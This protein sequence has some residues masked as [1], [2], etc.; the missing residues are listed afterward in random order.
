MR[1]AVQLAR[2]IDGVPRGER[3]RLLVGCSGGRDSVAVLGLLALVAEADGLTLT[4]GHV[5]HGLRDASAD[6]AAHVRGLAQRLGLPYREVRLDLERAASGLA[7]RAREARH[8]ALHRLRDELAA[9]RLV[10]AHTATDQ[11]ET[12]L[13]HLSRGAGLR[14]LGGMRVVETEAAVVRPLL[15]LPRAEMAS[16]C[17]RLGLAFVDDPTNVDA[18]HPR[19]R[20]RHDVLPA[21]GAERGGVEAA[22]A[23]S[24]RAAREADEALTAWIVREQDT[25]AGGS[26]YDLSGWRGL[27]RAVRVGLVQAIV[28]GSGFPLDAIGRRALDAIDR[29]LLAGGAKRWQLAGGG[30][31]RTDG[32]TLTITTGGEV[33]TPPDETT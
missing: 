17:A 33:R 28:V 11:A 22:L 6:E 5:D 8:G 19:V 13:L 1:A 27:P 23:A 32:E 3:L 18:S 21:L 9:H 4:V 20:I 25:R 26:G 7:A 30:E 15:T 16:L 12:V 31:V 10:L 29:G 14:G 2:R 24:A